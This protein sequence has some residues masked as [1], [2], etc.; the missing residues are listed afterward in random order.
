MFYTEKLAEAT[1]KYA[2]LQSEL[3]TAL[4]LQHGG[5]KHK[6]KATVKA[7]LPTRKLRELKL[8]FSEFY[9]SLIL[10]QNYQNL[11]YTGFRKILKKHDKVHNDKIM[12]INVRINPCLMFRISLGFQVHLNNNEKLRK[13]SNTYLLKF[14][15]LSCTSKKKLALLLSVVT[16]IC[17]NTSY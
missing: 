4:E 5:G 17:Y 3:K 16:C 7:H 11:N 8:A 9:L 10:L 14:L 13:R 1:R 15:I 2:A 12:F 6:G